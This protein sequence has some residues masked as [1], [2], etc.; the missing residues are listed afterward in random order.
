M[1]NNR[2]WGALEAAIRRASQSLQEDI[3]A[4]KLDGTEVVTCEDLLPAW[5]GGR[6]EAGDVRTHNGQVWKCVQAHDTANNPDVE[7]GATPAIWVPFHTKDPARA[8]P[9]IQ[10]TGAHDSYLKDEVMLWTD[11]QVYKSIMDGANTY[12][13]QDY[14]QG[15]QVVQ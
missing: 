15:W 6:F 14:P 12:S 1:S 13:P 7:P 8:K 3:R 11:G 4:D 10:P 5:A 9:F 2:T